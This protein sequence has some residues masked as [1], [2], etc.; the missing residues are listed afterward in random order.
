MLLS[1]MCLRRV[2]CGVLLGCFALAAPTFPTRA[3]PNAV[4]GYPSTPGAVLRAEQGVPLLFATHALSGEARVHMQA[5]REHVLARFQAEECPRTTAYVRALAE[6][7]LKGSKLDHFAQEAP[8]VRLVV[9][10]HGGPPL[11]IARASFGNV[12][13]VPA[14]LL[15]LAASEDAVAAVL[16]HELAHLSLRHAERLIT[17]MEALPEAERKPAAS[18]LKRTHERE[19]DVTGLRL[20]VNAGY[21]PAAASDHLKAV[22]ALAHGANLP[23]PSRSRARHAGPTHDAGPTRA[24][25]LEQQVRACG[26]GRVPRRAIPAFVQLELQSLSGGHAMSDGPDTSTQTK[27]L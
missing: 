7:L 27:R 18:A 11:P 12:V 3:Q 6:R 8:D 21:D 25:S 20:L 9:Q 22:E 17:R 1:R 16:A 15:R 13:L 24:R 4:C 23:R 19:A 2:A 10:C 5:H 14:S 26:Y